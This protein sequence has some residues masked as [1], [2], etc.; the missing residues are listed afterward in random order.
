M[1][2]EPSH[3][4][5]LVMLC[6]VDL[7]FPDA[8]RTHTVEVARG[9][10]GEG[11]DVELIAR[12]PDPEL[13]GVRYRAA[14]GGE[15]DRAQRLLSVNAAAIGALWRRRRSARRFY[16]RDSWSCFPALLAARMLGY[17]VVVQVDG[18][19][20][21]HVNVERQ[22]PPLEWIKRAVG[23]A[24]GR[25]ASG[26][27]AVTPQIQSLLV[28]IARVPPQRIAVIP[29]GVDLDVF[30]PLERAEAI[31]RLGLDPACRYIAFCGGFHPWTDF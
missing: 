3:A 16:V 21:G 6:D 26:I 2:P 23:I 5:G 12:G 15:Y 18:I 25:L 13:P 31:D 11:L 8:T 17:R 30:R 22:A 14:R 29:N 20:Y 27:L 9:F 4:R 24:T 19:P 7:S 10:A 1:P 28:S